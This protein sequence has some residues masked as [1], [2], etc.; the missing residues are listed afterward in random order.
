[1]NFSKS[2]AERP[3]SRQRSRPNCGQF[4][5]NSAKKCLFSLTKSQDPAAQYPNKYGW[6]IP[7]SGGITMLFAR[8]LRDRKGGVAPMLALAIIPLIGGVGAAVDY[9]RANLVRTTMQNALDSTALM[10]SKDAQTLSSADL[11][12][13]A[14]SYFNAL[15]QRPEASNVQV[16][17]QFS[18]PL[19]GSFNLKVTGSATV[20]TMFWRLIGQEQINITGIRRGDLGH[21]E[22]QSGARPRQ[23]R[24]DGLDQQDDGAQRAPRTICSTTL[25]NA[26]KTPGDIKVVDRSVRGRRQCRHRQRR[27]DWIDWA[28]WEAEERHLQQVLIYAVE[29]QLH[30]ATTESGRPRI[31]APGTA[32]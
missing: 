32:A 24:L 15:F 17:P 12:A 3:H 9:S 23:Y 18:S 13:K 21:Q 27:R 1:M 16:T 8:I 26:E 28:D 10:L 29:E 4:A 7:R 20:N 22:A 31:T 11:A 6:D 14:S 30:V 25:K 19:Q 2:R 5:A